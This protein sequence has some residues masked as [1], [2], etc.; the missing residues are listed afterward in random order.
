MIRSS[1]ESRFYL[2]CDTIFER[3]EGMKRWLTFIGLVYPCFLIW[4]ASWWWS[5]L[6]RWWLQWWLRCPLMMTSYWQFTEDGLQGFMFLTQG[7][8]ITIFY[9]SAVQEW[10]TFQ[11][12]S[13]PVSHRQSELSLDILYVF[14][15][16]ILVFRVSFMPFTASTWWCLSHFLGNGTPVSSCHAKLPINYWDGFNLVLWDS[17]M[18]RNFVTSEKQTLIVW[19]CNPFFKGS[20][21]TLRVF[22][23]NWNYITAY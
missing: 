17:E 20:A 23:E 22:M 6:S 11:S 9:Q 15:S 5:L 14:V 12:H 13:C 7:M 4:F 19:C 21:S 3:Q 10:L 18:E 16:T 1:S 2:F 8:L